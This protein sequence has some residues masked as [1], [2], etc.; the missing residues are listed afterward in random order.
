MGCRARPDKASG[1]E[2]QVTYLRNSLLV[3]VADEKLYFVRAFNPLARED[4]QLFAALSR[5]E[6]HIRGFTNQDLRAK[7]IECQAL[8]TVAQ[9]VQQ[10]A[11]KVS[12]LLRRLHLYGLIAKVSHA[13]RWR[14]T[15]K[16][17]RVFSSALRLRDY[18]FPELYATACA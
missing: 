14:V 1:A 18:V 13:R 4:R 8:K 17:L 2:A 6:H 7:L 15:R 9:T 16:G 3:D 10:L 5:G 11:G 12:R